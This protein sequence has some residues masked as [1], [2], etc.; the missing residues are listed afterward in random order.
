[1]RPLRAFLFSFAAGIAALLA[2]Q[3]VIVQLTYV[4]PEP[5]LQSPLPV[6][7]VA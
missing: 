1:M 3:L 5:P 6:S 4:P 2:A 7:V